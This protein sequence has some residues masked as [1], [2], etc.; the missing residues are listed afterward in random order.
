[1]VLGNLLTI[2]INGRVLYVEPVFTQAQG[3]SS[4]PILRYVIAVY[5]NGEPAFE[6]TL[7]AALQHAIA[8]D[9]R[10]R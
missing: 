5:G 9:A 4:F 10:S 7:D 6:P 1:V 3:G 2:P 8:N